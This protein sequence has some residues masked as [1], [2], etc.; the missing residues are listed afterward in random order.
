MRIRRYEHEPPGIR[1]HN[2][3]R[4][5][6][7]SSNLM[8]TFPC[9]DLVLTAYMIHVSNFQNL[10][11]N[12]WIKELRWVH[13]VRTCLSLLLSNLN[14]YIIVFA[15]LRRRWS[16]FSSYCDDFQRCMFRVWTWVRVRIRVNSQRCEPCDLTLESFPFMD[17]DLAWT[18]ECMTLT[19][20]LRVWYTG[21]DLFC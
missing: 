18:W 11:V 19:C 17:L 1:T 9:V 14:R 5:L 3:S 15:V 4:V 20:R 16:A 2:P 13:F 8:I 21:I 10:I 7:Q 12:H 6:L